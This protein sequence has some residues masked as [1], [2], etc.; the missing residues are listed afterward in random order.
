M[1][2][3]DSAEAAAQF[4]PRRFV[5]LARKVGHGSAL[6]I[7]YQDSGPDWLELALPWREELVGVPETGVLA[8]GAIVSLID[9]ASGGSVWMKLGRFVPIVTLDLRLDY[10][11]PALKGETV[12]A[13]C[14]CV[15]VTRQ[16]AF[17]RGVAHG[18]DPAHPIA[19]S[20][21]TFMVSR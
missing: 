4:D 12:F 3:A 15:K 13:R 18:G 21:A 5:E 14:E 8:S 16:V 2:K 17:V 10:M 20:A 19:Q 9:T 7:D 11:R 6:E 1:S